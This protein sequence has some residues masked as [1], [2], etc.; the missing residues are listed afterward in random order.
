MPAKPVP[1]FVNTIKVG[2]SVGAADQRD[3]QFFVMLDKLMR[4]DPP[5]NEWDKKFVANNLAPMGIGGEVPFDPGQLSADQ[6]NQFLDGIENGF[7]QVQKKI[8]N[9]GIPEKVWTSIL[10]RD[11]G[12]FFHA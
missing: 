9:V 2:A 5:W 7:K 11:M 8:R 1:T 4:F 12:F 3:I 10:L 6:K